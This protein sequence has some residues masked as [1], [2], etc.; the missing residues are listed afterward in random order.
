MSDNIWT[1][2]SRYGSLRTFV[3]DAENEKLYVICNDV[4]YISYTSHPIVKNNIPSMYESVDPDGGPYF[5]IG[6]KIYK[7]NTTYDI[8]DILSN[9]YDKKK[10]SVYGPIC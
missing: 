2:E 4:Q 8:L 3:Y 6:G 5:Y 1:E 10:M 9:R 7:K